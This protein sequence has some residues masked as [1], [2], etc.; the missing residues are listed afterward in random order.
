MALTDFTSYP[1]IRTVLGVSDD[2]IS[3][4]ELALPIREAE[5]MMDFDAVSPNLL[6]LYNLYKQ[7]PTPT[8][9]QRRLV[10]A[11]PVFAAYSVARRLL[12]SLPVFAPKKITDGRAELERIAD[13]YKY[14]RTDLP[15]ALQGVIAI[16]EAALEDLGE[17]TTSAVAPILAVSSINLDPVTGAAR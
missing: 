6:D 1:E 3:D 9:P 4:A 5:L 2:E 13:P 14:V 11:V 8:P 10:R 7:E 12:V 15:I 17:V 16:I